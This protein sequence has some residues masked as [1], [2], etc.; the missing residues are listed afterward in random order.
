MSTT[1]KLDVSK[2]LKLESTRPTPYFESFG[3]KVRCEVCE[4]RCIIP[5]GSLGFCKNRMNINGNLY[6]IGYGLLSAIESR[7]IEIKPLYHYYPG[8]TALTFSNWGCNFYCPWCQNYHLSFQKPEPEKDKYVPPEKLVEL[9]LKFGDE[10]VCASF[11][12]PTTQ[13][14]YL[15]EVFTHASNRKLYSCIV[16]N[17]YFTLKVLGDLL[18]SGLTGLSIDIKGCPK[19]HRKYIPG[20]DPE[21]IF[22]NARRALDRGA[23]VE[24][25]FLVIPGVNDEL[26]C[27]EWVINKHLDLL[28][29]D[30][31]L[32]VNRYYPAHKYLREP[33]SLE[34]L[35]KT[36]DIAKSE[37][38]KYVY[39]GN[40]GRPEYESTYCPSCGKLLIYR[41]GYRVFE[42]RMLGDNRCPRCGEKILLYGRII[43]KN[44]L[45]NLRL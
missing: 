44:R 29:E 3:D 24:M 26:E 43:C 40:V 33:T 21:I 20:V 17:G 22:R 45:W 14:E 2:L 8:S 38:L 34:V 6:T 7:P 10:G 42:T 4:R 11:N 36:Y 39:I 16:T 31:P 9:A 13:A 35:K 18:E 37:G 1:G 41:S 15:L 30:V 27:L 23:H 25:V 28:G 12:E 19:S 5:E 32:H